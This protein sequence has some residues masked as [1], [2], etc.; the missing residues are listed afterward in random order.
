MKAIRA[1]HTL[2]A[3]LLLTGANLPSAAQEMGVAGPA[4][5]WELV[6]LTGNTPFHQAI[7]VIQTFARKVVVFPQELSAPI[8]V[9][10]DRAPWRRALQLIAA[11]HG[12]AVE[13]RPNYLELTPAQEQG[14]GVE[15]AE[16]EYTVDSRE[17]NISATFFQADRTALRQVGIDW[18]TISGGRVD[19]SATHQGASLVTGSPFAIG[20][21]GFINRSMSVD[22]LL[23]TFESNNVGEVVANP[24]IKVRSGQTGH[25]QV[26]SDFSVTTADFAGNAITQFFSTGTI[27]TVTPKLILE[28]GIEYVDLQVEAERSSLVDPDRNLI[29]KTVARTATL[30]KDGER[31]AIGGLFGQEVTKARTGIPMLK[32]LPGWFFGLRYFFGRTSDQIVKTDLIVLLRVNVVP[33]VRQRVLQGESAEAETDI[34]ERRMRAFREMMEE[35]R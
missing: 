2:T 8:G 15:E 20:V 17:I 22:M 29:S 27:L 24:Q 13:A 32:D 21:R 33:S 26:G 14:G 34:I 4:R 3:A 7:A 28:E 6:S 18:S 1:I 5:E 35:M 9:S 23:R 19:V 12:L 31:T 16:P 10:V 30:L 11:N 25:I